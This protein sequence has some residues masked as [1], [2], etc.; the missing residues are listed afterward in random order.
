MK[1]LPYIEYRNR[2]DHA[3]HLV[4]FSFLFCKDHYIRC[5][6][7]VPYFEI[8]EYVKN[9]RLWNFRHIHEERTKLGWTTGHPYIIQD[10]AC[11]KCHKKFPSFESLVTSIR[12]QTFKGSSQIKV[13]HG[14]LEYID[15]P[16][17]IFPPYK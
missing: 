15:K 9:V 13:V 17:N 4:T 3:T 16:K 8:G 14:K 12:L 2:F 1:D 6:V 5:D 7:S 10:G 11:K